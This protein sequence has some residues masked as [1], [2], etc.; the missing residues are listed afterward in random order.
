MTA[1][2]YFLKTNPVRAM[3]VVNALIVCATAFGLH[4]TTDQIVAVTGLASVVL[5]IGGELVRSQ[6][7][8]MASLPDHVAAAVAASMDADVPKRAAVAG[9]VTPL[10]PPVQTPPAPLTSDPPQVKP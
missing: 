7:T 8:P 4:L 2:V 6:V 1:V 10:A 3:A 9:T 5:G